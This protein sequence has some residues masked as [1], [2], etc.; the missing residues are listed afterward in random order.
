MTSSPRQLDALSS[1]AFINR[2]AQIGTVE[3]IYAA[4]RRS[5]EVRS[6]HAAMREEMVNEADIEA[7]VR[8]LLQAFV[9]ASNFHINYPSR[10]SPLPALELTKHLRET[11]LRIWQACARS[12]CN[13][14]LRSLIKH[15]SRYQRPFGKQLLKG[16]LIMRFG[17]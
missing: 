14:R 1:D 15:S 6:L 17:I 11:L 9:P 7:Y 12:R 10:P 5:R 13:L 3:G 16:L 2:F 4:M 8:A